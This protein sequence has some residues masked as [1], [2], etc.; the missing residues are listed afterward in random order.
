MRH[1]E[2]L[3]VPPTGP[4]FGSLAHDNSRERVR[5]RQ[6]NAAVTSGFKKPTRGARGSRGQLVGRGFLPF[7]RSAI[8]HLA[9]VAQAGRPATTRNKLCAENAT[10]RSRSAGPCGI[11]LGMDFEQ[12]LKHGDLDAAR[13]SLDELVQLPD[14]G[15]L[16]MPE[17]YADLAREY[18]RE[19]RRDDAIALHERAIELGWDSIP[20]PRS[21]IAE[22]HL[23]AGRK[24]EAATANGSNLNDHGSGD[25]WRTGAA[26]NEHRLSCG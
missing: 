25:E 6:G 23:R 13:A 4:P 10:T 17:C 18:D 2:Q 11:S 3:G 12:A 14:T 5:L 8:H 15:G 21:D 26:G 24:G 7:Y 1:P 22:F 19:G 16:W 9:R 20:D